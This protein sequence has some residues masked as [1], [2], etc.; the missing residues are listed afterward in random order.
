MA[1]GQTA[2]V[3]NCVGAIFGN[4]SGAVHHQLMGPHSLG[5]HVR[6]SF[7]QNMFHFN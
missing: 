2:Q 6:G 7:M 1:Y 4:E 3:Y 5:A